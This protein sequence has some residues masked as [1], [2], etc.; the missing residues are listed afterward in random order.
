M[1]EGQ[2][3]G[4]EGIVTKHLSEELHI[5]RGVTAE[6]Y[7]ALCRTA[8]DACHPSPGFHKILI[9]PLRPI[10]AMLANSTQEYIHW[11]AADEIEAQ[12]D[13]STEIRCVSVGA[14]KPDFS[15]GADDGPTPSSEEPDEP[16]TRRYMLA[17][18]DVLGFSALLQEKGLSE[19]TTLYSRLI[20]ETVTKEGMRAYSIVRFS[21]TQKGSVLGVAPIRH[22]HFSDTILLWV[23]LVQHFIGPFMA[24]CADMVCEALRMGLPL[25]GALAVGPAVMHSR[26]GTFVG[27]PVVEAA[28]LEQA[29]D[30][31]GVCL[32]PSMLAADVSREFDPYLVVPYKIPFKTGKA[33]NVSDLALDWPSRFRASYGV[34]P[35]SAIRAIDRSPAHRI[36]YDNAVKFAE[37]SAGPIFRSEGFH[38]P[39]LGELADAAIRARRENAPLTPHHEL[40]LKDISRTD[41]VGALVAKFVRAIAVG[42]NPPDIPNDVPDGLQRYLRE[43][44]LASH[45]T[46]KFFKLVPCVV[47]A[48]CMR[49]SGTPL[50]QNADGMLTELEGLGK[51]GRETS[52]FLRDLANGRTPVVPRKLRNGMGPFLKQALAWATQG[53][54]PSGLVAHV[55]EDCMGA[56]LDYAPLDDGALRA[57]AALEATGG[58]WPH[59]VAFLRGIAAGE[60]PAVS[61]EIPE[62]TRSNLVRVSLTSRLAGVQQPRTL[63][64]ISVGFGDPATG[65]DL[66]SLV[67]ALVALRGHVTDIPHE[68]EDAIRRFE[69][70]TPERAIVAQRLRAI[71]SETP[72]MA[73][74][75]TLPMALRVV[76]VQIEAV[77]KG[78]GIP[79]D[80]SL[81][82][83]AAIRSRHGGGPMG[84]CILFSL[85]AMARATAE[86]EVLAN[87]LWRI[88]N[89]G[90]AGPAPLL[91]EPQLAETAEEVRC[92]AD[93]EVG[94]IRLMMTQAKAPIG[95]EFLG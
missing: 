38:P 52:K 91:T 69:A 40:T 88:A 68:A 66:F 43:L 19:I 60:D 50:S 17:V 45:G 20:A 86:A 94:G 70:A 30:W 3:D 53:K 51:D 58:N 42:E 59:V 80:P 78:A 90:P 10:E 54:V 85:H 31:L 89:G 21:K 92:L 73:P 63:E 56:R 44:S 74:P 72:Q 76:L 37:F 41:A 29:Q 12:K 13:P 75:D 9:D 62:P 95:A 7:T 33:N 26:T 22:A 32:G 25:R 65:I 16:E 23:P 81:V 14:V 48:I 8:W 18:F 93:K 84:D 36:Y 57:L 46:A 64:I 5:R 1:S 39:N 67:E 47:E 71:I 11:R 28:K 2:D 77:A 82:G 6:E 55:A 27:A 49:L 4:F 83:L 15:A 34:T 79:L 35:V 24:R 61:T 87:Y